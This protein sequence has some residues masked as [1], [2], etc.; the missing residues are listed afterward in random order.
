MTIACDVRHSERGIQGL[1]MGD[2]IRLSR[3]RKR[4][5]TTCRARESGLQRMRLL[6][7]LTHLA[8]GS[9]AYFG[10]GVT[11]CDAKD[12]GWLQQASSTFS[13]NTLTGRASVIDGDT[14]E[15]HGRRIR[16]YGIDAPES[17]QLCRDR[18]AKSFRC[19]A[20]SAAALADFLKVSS[21]TR[22]EFIDGDRYGRFVGNCFRA[23]GS[24]VQELLVRS[25]WAMDWP[26]YSNGTYAVYQEAAKAERIGIWAGEFQP[27]WEWRKAGGVTRRIP[28]AKVGP[29]ANAP[30]DTEACDI[31]GNISSNGERIYHL[32]GQEH[33]DRTKIS[34]SKGEKWFCSEGEARA[35]GWRRAHR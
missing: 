26:R 16:L 25:G 35:A 2:I 3:C 9:A 23:D 19:G 10:A 20:T 6:L 30:Q 14:I 28:S 24:S 34:T 13:S 7:P 29:L 5:S 4:R 12:S 33:Y 21:P 8:L 22:C 17:A 1:E 15:I 31:K 18:A 27:P 11:P 32:P